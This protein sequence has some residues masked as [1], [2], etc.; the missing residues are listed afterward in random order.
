MWYKLAQ[1]VERAID[2]LK[3]KGVNED[4]ITNLQAMDDVA[5]RGRYIGALMQN[6]LM[7][8]DELQGKFQTNQLQKVSNEELRLLGDISTRLSAANIPEEQKANFYK[9]VERVALPSYRP[10]QHDPEN[11]SYPKFSHIV[12]GPIIGVTNEL[13][14]VLDWYV[15]HVDENPRF[16]IF[17]LT[18][19]Q[20]SRASEQWHEELANQTPG[21]AYSKIKKENGKI[22]DPN[23]VMIFDAATVKIGRAHV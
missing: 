21:A 9:W 5:L 23:V 15:E 11:F 12:I 1:N 14:H 22:V 16:N 6:P 17:S 3:S 13:Y 10:N 4:I 7:T 19:E 8:W 20:A 18:L 2:T